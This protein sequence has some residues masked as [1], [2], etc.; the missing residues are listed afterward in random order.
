MIREQAEAFLEKRGTPC[1][2]EEMARQSGGDPILWAACLR[3][4]VDR[5]PFG[6]LWRTEGEVYGLTAWGVPWNA[7]LPVEVIR[8]KNAYQRKKVQEQAASLGPRTCGTCKYIEYNEVQVVTR[9]RG[10]CRHYKVSGKHVVDATSFVCPHWIA[11]SPLKRRADEERG[12]QVRE[13]IEAINEGR[14]RATQ[15]SRRRR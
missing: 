9:Q 3:D 2:V 13:T 12:R 15:R 11:R 4:Y 6:P 10:Y 7:V 8:P 1:P 14:Y 5:N